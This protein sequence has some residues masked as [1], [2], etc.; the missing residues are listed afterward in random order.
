M[1]FFTEKSSKAI[2]ITFTS[3]IYTGLSVF[4]SALEAGF[5]NISKMPFLAFEC[6]REI[7]NIYIKKKIN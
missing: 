5:F 3:D 4:A 2:A 7:F 6:H 1:T